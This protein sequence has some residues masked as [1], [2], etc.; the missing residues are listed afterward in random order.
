MNLLLVKTGKLDTVGKS[1]IPQ[2]R[3][4]TIKTKVIFEISLEGS[5]CQVID[6]AFHP[7]T[8]M[9]AARKEFQ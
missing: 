3:F 9:F 8:Y 2:G 4:D 6:V 5:P 7:D 1:Q